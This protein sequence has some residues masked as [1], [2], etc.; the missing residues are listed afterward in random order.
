[1]RNFFQISTFARGG[2]KL[3][4]VPKQP[5]SDNVNQQKT[6]VNSLKMWME[7]FEYGSNTLKAE[8]F[9]K[10][11]EGTGRVEREIRGMVDD[12]SGLLNWLDG[13]AFRLEPESTTYLHDDI[14]KHSFVY[15][16]QERYPDISE[17]FLSIILFM[18]LLLFSVAI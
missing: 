2:T 12:E 11:E 18:G 7:K 15:S 1:M 5:F 14:R 16:Q 17:S 13:S 6:F 3:D 8:V 10:Q 9:L 4:C